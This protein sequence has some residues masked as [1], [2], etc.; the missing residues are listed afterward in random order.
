[1]D[2]AKRFP[3]IAAGGMLL[4]VAVVLAQ[5][6][7]SK[8]EFEVASI[9]PAQPLPSQAS[10]GKIHVGMTIDGARV[11]IG[12][13]SLAELIPVAFKVKPY[14]VSGPDWMSTE[15]FDI[16]AKIPD[17]AANDQ[18]PEMLQA[19]LA[20]RFKLTIHRENKDHSIY[21][22]VVAKGGPKLKESVP[23]P[24]V[25]ESSDDA[26]KAVAIATLDGSVR[27]TQDNKGGIV[28]R[29]GQGGTTRIAA[30]PD[31]L[32]HMEASRVTMAQLADTLSRFVD[33]PVVDMTDLKGNYQVKLEISMAEI[34]KSARAAGLPGAPLPGG[35]LGAGTPADAAS[36]PSS[37]SIFAT[38]QQLG[39]KLEPR[40]A[41]IETIVVDHLEKTPT[42]N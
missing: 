12:S 10:S 20:D 36:D 27:V 41:P 19:L 21:A 7:V 37:S 1:M 9:K 40:K 14:Q 13:M 15:R 22:L 8:P 24:E 28:T 2:I 30:G 42:E 16:L 39:L 18:V 31:G 35:P 34:M 5:A 25:L 3:K 4:A 29:G 6:P 38:V 17:G 33:R 26:K 11:D 32:M 23:E